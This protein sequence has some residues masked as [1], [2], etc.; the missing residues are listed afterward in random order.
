MLPLVSKSVSP[1]DQYET[2]RID[3]KKDI[4][5]N[6]NIKKKSASYYRQSSGNDGNQDTSPL[7]LG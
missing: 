2:P 3:V 4:V 7:M 6:D 5:I 1:I